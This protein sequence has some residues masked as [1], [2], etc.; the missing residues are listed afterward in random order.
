MDYSVSASNMKTTKSFF[1]RTYGCQMNVYDSQKITAL[2]ET[3]NM[4][5]ADSL[6]T[7]DIIVINTCHIREKAAE[8]IY[9]ELGRIARIKKNNAV[10][11]IAGCMAQYEG[12]AITKRAPIVDIVVGP[13]SYH[14]VVDLIKQVE[15]GEKHIVSVNNNVE[16]KF[17]VVGTLFHSSN[18]CAS[19]FV[20]VQEGCDKFCHYCVVPYTRGRQYSRSV[21]EILLEIEKLIAHD[22][23]EIILLGQNFS[24]YSGIGLDGRRW[25]AG[26]LIKNIAQ[27]DNVHR[28]FYMTSH[29]IDMEMS[30]L[31]EAHMEEEKLMPFM[32]IPMQSGSNTILQ[33]MNRKHDSNF[34]ID[35]IEKF[36]K[37]YPGIAFSSDFI[38]GY[39]G[40][41]EKDFEQT[42]NIVQQVGYAQA[43][44][45]KYSVRPNTPAAIM[46]KQIPDNVKKQ[47]LH[48][49]Q[50]Y[51]LE[52]Q[53]QFNK[54]KIGEEMSILV[55]KYGKKPEQ[56]I[57]RSPYMQSVFFNIDERVKS[58]LIGKIAKV[59]IVDAF[60]NSLK[61]EL[62]G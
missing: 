58:E 37:I 6:A 19:A 52:A 46:E 26:Q 35:I 62:L 20:S 32:H 44:S 50:R 9:A 17:D 48:V 40:E 43:F 59:K 28:I 34:Y 8:K 15:L 27:L 51:I 13:Q 47:R 4:V 2:L 36:R 7:A 56:L 55:T 10:I 21:Q 3:H 18:I 14:H 12:T 29:P 31:Y 45:F 60:H 61:G 54:S 33:A 1:V 38:V 39:P 11:I 49:L 57:G 25:N 30:G 16:E 22:V 42:L 41:T 53:L 23:K 24:S 5:A